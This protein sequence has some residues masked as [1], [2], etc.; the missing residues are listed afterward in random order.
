MTGFVVTGEPTGT[1]LVAASAT[2]CEL[3]DLP[4]APGYTFTVRATNEAGA[5]APSATTP[6]VSVYSAPGRPVALDAA[7]GNQLALLTWT[8]PLQDGN[9]PITDYLVD[10][11]GAGEADWITVA[12]P[13][14]P[15]TTRVVSGLVNGTS[16]EFQV[17]AV[18]EAGVSDPP[19][20]LAATTPATVPGE[21]PTLTQVSGNESSTLT[22]TAPATDGESP[23]T[24]YA[25]QFHA[26]GDPWQDYA[27]PASRGLTADVTGLENGT[28]YAFR[29]A[30]VNA[31]GQGPWSPRVLGRPVGPPGPVVEPE[32]VGYLTE[33]ELTW[34]PPENDG[35]RRLLGY[36]VEYKVSAD[37]DWITLPR[38]PSDV[39]TATV[40]DLVAGE[41]YD[42]R[43]MAVS[44]AGIGPATVD[45][46]DRPTL[47]GV[48]AD[49][50]PP[51]PK[52]L[53][54]IPGD[55]SVTLRWRASPAG[56]DSPITAYTVTGVPTGSCTTKRLTCV[57]RGL[58]NGAPISFTVS[59]SNKNIT[60]PESKPVTAT[61]KVF[62][63]AS[64]GEVS[65]YTR[66][67]RTFRV[68]TFFTG[69]TFTVAAG[70]LPFS[71]LVVAGGAGSSVGADGSVVVGGGGAILE[72]GRVRLPDGALAVGVGAGGSPGSTGGASSLDGVGTAPGGSVTPGEFSPV[73]TSA[74]SGTDVTYGGNGTPTSGPG[75]DGRGTGGGGPEANRGGNG[76][77]IIR[78][79]VA[80]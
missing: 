47:A 14:S 34:E 12:H 68:H 62:N 63:E 66:G 7:P 60:G 39:T 42:F 38:I 65:T 24:D 20:T 27:H 79:E 73:T 78:Y 15:D 70:G 31:M 43:I 48:I 75:A 59:A 49:E 30:A 57:V 35:G 10:Y 67:G 55:G 28:T 44:R 9:T 41:A 46:S 56:P 76:I 5:S 58:T 71:V 69:G 18:N 21:V 74:I 54:A 2:R 16:Y 51:A 53:A 19:L 72:A 80:R 13:E 11:R 77:V 50:T 29:V 8:P 33:I 25:I 26:K 52:G 1:C 45:G 40:E 32:S 17:R 3:T 4:A 37:I 22:W 36:R 23:L 6:P 64:G 61:P